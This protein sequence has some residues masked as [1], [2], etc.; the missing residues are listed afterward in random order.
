MWGSSTPP[1]PPPWDIPNEPWSKPIVI[2][3]PPA[4]T[5]TISTINNNITNFYNELTANPKTFFYLEQ[6]K[7]LGGPQNNSYIPEWS[8]P[9][10]TPA[11]EYNCNEYNNELHNTNQNCLRAL[12]S[13]CNTDIE[14][15]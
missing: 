4:T 2:S 9:I 7:V 15:C 12:I 5:P 10:F 8:P 1:P 3:T 6:L 11:K 13:N 14:N